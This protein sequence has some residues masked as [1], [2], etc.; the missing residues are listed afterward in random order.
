MDEGPL[1]RSRSVAG[2]SFPVADLEGGFSPLPLSNSR[3]SSQ[4]NLLVSSPQPQP[5]QPS[6]PKVKRCRSCSPKILGALLIALLF[7]FLYSSEPNSSLS[8]PSDPSDP[9]YPSSSNNKNYKQFGGAINRGKFSVADATIT[10]TSFHI[11][12]VADL[13]HESKMPGEKLEFFSLLMGGVVTKFEDGRYMI[14][15]GEPRRVTSKHNEAGRGMELSELVVFDNRLL[16]FGDRTGIVFE[17]L[18]EEEEEEGPSS[19]EDNPNP[20]AIKVVPRFIVTEGNG[21]TDKGMKIEWATEKDGKLFLGSFGKEFTATSGAIINKNNLW[22]AVL[23]HEGHVSR[24]DW[25][26]NY[27]KLRRSLDAEFPGYL[28]HESVL[29]SAKMKSWI[30]VPRRVSTTVYE[31]VEDERKGSNILLR[32]DESFSTIEKVEINFGEEQVGLRGFSR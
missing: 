8:D 27:E 23:D 10:P 12:A 14:T 22:I 9:S 21:E 32:A 20:P 25:S 4:C 2:P 17:C 11:A 28:I 13:D 5:Q 19:S 29:W 30:F 31:E 16:T 7:L 24:H 6:P 1:R 3:N 26:E 18:K 15:W